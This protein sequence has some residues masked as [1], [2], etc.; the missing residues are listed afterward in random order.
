LL[1]QK[2]KKQPI[3]FLPLALAITCA[4][5]FLLFTKTAGGLTLYRIIFELP[6]MSAMRVV[7]RFVHVQLFMVLLLG[8]LFFIKQKKWLIYGLALLC[9]IDNL[10]NPEKVG[11]TAKAEIQQHKQSLVSKIKSYDFK[12]YKA[13]AYIADNDDPFFVKNIDAMVASQ[14]LNIK[15]VNGY[16]SACPG[17]FGGMFS[18]CNQAGLD[19][20]LKACNIRKEDIL[21]VK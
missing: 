20:W 7:P 21:V 9:I 19:Q 2:R 18:N 13:I 6:G 5:T 3:D 15:C 11:T 16:S 8:A 1:I 10:F 17:E 14:S 12:N 4:I